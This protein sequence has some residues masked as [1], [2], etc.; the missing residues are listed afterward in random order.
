VEGRG[1]CINVKW[2]VVVRAAAQRSGGGYKEVRRANQCKAGREEVGGGAVSP[3]QVKVE[4]GSG[5]RA[6]MPVA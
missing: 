6:H 1:R 4:W 2:C 5:R 3:A